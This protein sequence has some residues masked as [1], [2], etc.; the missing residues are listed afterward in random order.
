MP[1]EYLSCIDPMWFTHMHTFH[2]TSILMMWILLLSHLYCINSLANDADVSLYSLGFYHVMH[3]V[4]SSKC[5]DLLLFA[6]WIL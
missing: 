3:G 5:H 1:T 6:Q 2:P 4:L